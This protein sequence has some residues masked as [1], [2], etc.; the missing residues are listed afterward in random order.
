[1]VPSIPPWEV[2]QVAM[3]KI[4]VQ[5]ACKHEMHEA[6][7]Q[8]PMILGICFLCGGIPNVVNAEQFLYGSQYP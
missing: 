5:L 4:S 2:S 8:A 1:M 3:R 7:S 6:I